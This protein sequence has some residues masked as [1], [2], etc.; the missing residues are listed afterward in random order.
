MKSIHN[1]NH[2]AKS[3]QCGKPFLREWCGF[4]LIQQNWR[5]FR[6]LLGILLSA[7]AL[8][9]MQ[10]RGY[11]RSRTD[12]TRWREFTNFD[13]SSLLHWEASLCF[14]PWCST[15]ECWSSLF[16]GCVLCTSS[17]MTASVFIPHCSTKGTA[18]SVFS[19]STDKITFSEDEQGSCKD[20]LPPIF[21]FLD[22]KV[23]STSNE[24]HSSTISWLLAKAKPEGKSSF[25]S[26]EPL[27]TGGTLVSQVSSHLDDISLLRE[28]T[29]VLTD[30]LSPTNEQLCVDSSTLFNDSGT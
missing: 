24:E 19:V 7:Q 20:A 1:R 13:G 10:L 30:F 26:T 22:P 28:C 29:K 9:M 23:V 12:K 14:F 2:L 8:I 11:S 17:N 27:Q 15:S 16:T 5:M 3:L 6:L 18:H 21:V 25:P 4:Q